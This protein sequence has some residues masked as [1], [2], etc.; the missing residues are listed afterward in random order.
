MHDHAPDP[1]R[2]LD[3]HTTRLV[4]HLIAMGQL[5]PSRLPAAERLNAI[6]S[7]P[8]L[9]VLRVSLDLPSAISTM[10]GRDRP[11]RIA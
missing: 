6:L 8:L 11:R 5:E 1:G 4:R 7:E 2:P 9:E 10:S 3:P